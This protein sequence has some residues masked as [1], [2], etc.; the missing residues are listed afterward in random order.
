MIAADAALRRRQTLQPVGGK[1]DKLFPSTYPGEKRSQNDKP[2]PR[3]VYERRRVGDREAWCALVDSVQSQAN[4]LEECLRDAISEGLPVP[5]LVVDFGAANLAGIRTLTSLDAPH[6]VYDAILRDS[7]VDGVAFPTSTLGVRLA[8]ARPEDAGAI[9]EA[10][11]TALLFGSWN[12]TG[13]G[14]GLGAKFARCLTSEIVAIDV[15]VDEPA[16]SSSRR[17]GPAAEAVTAARRT[18]SRIDPL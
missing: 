11:P 17:S 5:H 8:Q 16:E 9:L 6:R 2:P 3:H 7:L 10:S 15:P 12:S 13:Q 4:R 1:G 14:G 18:G